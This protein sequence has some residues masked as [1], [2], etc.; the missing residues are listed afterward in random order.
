MFKKI[1]SILISVLFAVMMFGG[2]AFAAQSWQKVYGSWA[3]TAGESIVLGDVLCFS[4]YT[5]T[6]GKI[7][8]ADADNSARRPAIGIA[9]SAAGDGTTV[10]VV[11]SGI[12]TGNSGLTIGN[13][14]Y[15][16]DTAGSIIYTAVSAYPQ[17]IATCISSTRYQINFSP[18]SLNYGAV[19]GTTGTFSGGISATTG[20]FSG[21]VSGTT[22]TFTGAVSGTTGTFS[23]DISVAGG[24]G[25]LM[26]FD[27]DN[28][29]TGQTGVDLTTSG[30][31]TVAKHIAVWNGSVRG[32]FIRSNEA[33]SAGSIIVDVTVNSASTGLQATIDNTNTQEAYSV[34][35]KDVDAFSA[36]DRIGV[37][38][39]T[40]GD[41]APTTADFNI[42]VYT[43]Q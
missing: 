9:Q 5:A 33:R 41:W 29:T 21:A 23:G 31:A 18:Y 13:V 16:S 1:Q 40:S 24:I 35:N 36:G 8:K 26:T 32:I 27:D 37:T 19:S 12:M 15:L 3:G 7:F 43:E 17:E 22:G 11:T 39:T 42:G 14:K 25:Y 30:S 10:N 38:Y 6:T 4:R 28:L 20:T 34:Q 2:N